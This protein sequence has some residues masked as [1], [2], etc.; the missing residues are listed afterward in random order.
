[1]QALNLV[2]FSPTNSTLEVLRSI[3]VNLNIE[4]INEFDLS[5]PEL[6]AQKLSFRSDEL[7]LLGMPVHMGRIPPLFHDHLNLEGD[8]TPVVLC[9]V[10]GNRHYDDALLELKDLVENSGFNPIAAGAFIA[11][12]SLNG[13]IAA[14]RPDAADRQ[15]MAAFSVKILNKLESP[16]T[17]EVPGKRPY[18]RYIGLPF[19]PTVTDSCN[20]CGLCIESCPVQAIDPDTSKV[21]DDC[22]MCFRCVKVCPQGARAITGA[23][24]L[25]FKGA[26]KGL[27][28]ACLKR[29][30]P[31][32]FI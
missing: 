26:M 18:K 21:S 4:T 28:V 23:K 14:N 11:Q 25:A 31:E 12:H 10:Y 2:Y 6:R 5:R 7:V 15:Q 32:F 9:A 16:S 22:L 13:N 27:E 24:G 29:R 30:E 8:N 19:V 20:Q 17:V 1:M 3:A